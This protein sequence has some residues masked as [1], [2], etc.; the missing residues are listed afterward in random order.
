[1]ENKGN[2]NNT[3][4]PNNNNNKVPQQQQ[5]KSPQTHWSLQDELSSRETESKYYMECQP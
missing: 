3:P 5:Q 1:M 4:P 2:N